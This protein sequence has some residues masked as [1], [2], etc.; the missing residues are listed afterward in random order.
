MKAV[1]W[2]KS[3]SVDA[4]DNRQ[5]VVEKWREN[6]TFNGELPVVSEIGTKG[7]GATRTA[8]WK[9]TH[10]WAMSLGTKSIDV[11]IPNQVLVTPSIYYSYVTVS[12]GRFTT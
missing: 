11:A 12:C 1:V 4:M 8:K 3:G 5:G 10:L 9:S 2:L 7:Y 6:Q